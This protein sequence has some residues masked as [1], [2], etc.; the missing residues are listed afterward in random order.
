[1]RE[2]RDESR[3]ADDEEDEQQRDRE[4][5]VGDSWLEVL[6]RRMRRCA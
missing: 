3:I 2:D 6:H 1:M 5:N 4:D